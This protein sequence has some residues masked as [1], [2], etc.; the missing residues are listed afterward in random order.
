MVFSDG[1]AAGV[2]PRDNERIKAVPKLKAYRDG[3]CLIQ[4][5]MPR[6]QDDALVPRCGRAAV[7]LMGEL[8]LGKDQV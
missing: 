4:R 2:R 7:E 8:R 1:F 3:L 5:R 6:A